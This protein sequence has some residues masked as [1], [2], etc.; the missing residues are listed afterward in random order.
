M[1]PDATMVKSTM[2]SILAALVSNSQHNPSHN[3]TMHANRIKLPVDIIASRFV[4]LIGKG[5]HIFCD[6]I[7]YKR[8]FSCVSTFIINYMAGT[9]IGLCHVKSISPCGIIGFLSAQ[10]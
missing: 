1:M 6:I 7:A 5:N 10:Y 9:V 8:F 2:K 3:S 4:G